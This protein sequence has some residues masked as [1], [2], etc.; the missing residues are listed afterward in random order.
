MGANELDFTLSKSFKLGEKRDLRFDVTSYNVANKKQ[1]SSPNV[2]MYS[3]GWGTGP[4][5]DQF[6]QIT[7]DANLPRQFQFVARYTF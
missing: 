5:G 7:S 6:G 3:S 4:A 1:F 2:P